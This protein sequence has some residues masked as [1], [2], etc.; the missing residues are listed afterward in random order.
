MA[1]ERGPTVGAVH[2][3]DAEDGVL[4]GGAVDVG[5][6]VGDRRGQVGPAVPAARREPTGRRRSGDGTAGT[7][8]LP[9]L[10]GALAEQSDDRLA[11]TAQVTD[12]A[13]DH[14]GGD[15]FALPYQ[16]E[17]QVLGADVAMAELER[18]SE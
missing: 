2:D 18:L 11:D 9:R 12:L 6:P 17:E 14:L 1:A 5:Q 7:A 4:I 15:T 16:S 3:G 13:D 8:R 10:L